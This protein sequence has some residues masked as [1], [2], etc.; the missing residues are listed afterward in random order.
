VPFS[1]SETI[2]KDFTAHDSSWTVYPKFLLISL[3]EL[4]A[5]TMAKRIFTAYTDLARRPKWP[6]D[7]SALL[8]K[9]TTWTW[10]ITL[11]WQAKSI[12]KSPL[13]S[14]LDLFIFVQF[15]AIQMTF[16]LQKEYF[17][18]DK[19]GKPVKEEIDEET[20]K[21]AEESLNSHSGYDDQDFITLKPPK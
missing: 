9:V 4:G 3:T 10:R 14:R 13:L 6:K 18:L 21:A 17:M 5:A 15:D 12:I 1:A 11:Q 16:L 19:D 7:W 2:E 8:G 20:V